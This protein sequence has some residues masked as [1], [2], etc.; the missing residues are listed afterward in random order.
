MVT[1][2]I[3]RFFGKIRNW[4]CDLWNRIYLFASRHQKLCFWLVSVLAFIIMFAW[5][6]SKPYSDVD[7]FDF[8][9]DFATHQKL[10]SPRQIFESQ[11]ALWKAHTGRVL[12][13]GHLQLM[14][15]MGKKTISAEMSA[16]LILVPLLTVLLA[17]PEDK[18]QP[19]LVLLLMALF[20][21]LN[22]LWDEV[23]WVT[24]FEVYITTAIPILL[25]LYV[26][27]A[28]LRGIKIKKWLNNAVVMSVLGFMAGCSVEA[29][30][31]GV[32]I[33]GLYMVFRMHENH[34]LKPR[35][36]TAFLFLA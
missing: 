12:A 24:G 28:D 16:V 26:F 20:Y 35:H 19:L 18:F 10:T 17:L 8:Q 9:N 23:M 27:T 15:L 3:M 13:H 6:Y 5:F 22:P 14:L 36:V 30:A 2:F 33:V 25:F 32:G 11:Y 4:F 31:A 34:V 7:D 1:T 29:M 21:Y